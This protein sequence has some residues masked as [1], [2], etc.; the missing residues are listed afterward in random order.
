MNTNETQA[1]QQ[2]PKWG[3]VSTWFASMEIGVPVVFS[4]EDYFRIRSATCNLR[5]KSGQEFRL[6]MNR[7]N[8]TCTVTRTK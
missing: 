7:D 8:A 4:M 3:D 2:Y 1:V 6:N 5:Y